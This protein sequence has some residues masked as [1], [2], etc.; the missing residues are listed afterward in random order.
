MVPRVGTYLDVVLIK[1]P[2]RV[3]TAKHACRFIHP[4]GELNKAN[5]CKLNDTELIDIGIGSHS[6]PIHETRNID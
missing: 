6:F 4:L 5:K 3:V 2:N 1:V